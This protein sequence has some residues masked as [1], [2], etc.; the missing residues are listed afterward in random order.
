MSTK[1]GKPV[2]VEALLAQAE[3]AQPAALKTAIANHAEAENKKQVARLQAQF[4]LA[5]QY[6]SDAVE[7]L[8]ERRKQEAKAKTQL[9]AIAEA[10][11][12]FL[13][14]GDVS[15][16]AKAASDG[17]SY[18]QSRI[19]DQFRQAADRAEQALLNPHGSSSRY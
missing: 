11:A 9:T 10:H 15:A 19:N 6:V 5:S 14:T 12:E 4:G 13:K 2:D 3:A 16:L 8:R 17:D 18:T 7:T 1:Q